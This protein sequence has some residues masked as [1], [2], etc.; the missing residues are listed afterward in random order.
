MIQAISH[1]P[2][3]LLKCLPVSLARKC[4]MV[5]SER[6]ALP[7]AI[8]HDKPS[9][10]Q[11]HQGGR[12]PTAAMQPQQ[13]LVDVSVIHQTD[14]RT[15][16]QRAV[17]SLLLQL[18]AAPPV[19]FKVCPVFA[20]RRHGYRYADPDFLV[21]PQRVT[22]TPKRQTAAKVQ[23]RNGDLFLALDLAAHLLPRHQSQVLNWKRLGTK[24]HVVMYDLLPLQHPEWFNPKTTR[25]FKRWVTWLAIYAD[26][27]I[28]ISD[29]VKTDLHA[30]LNR[31]F[32]LQPADLP[33]STIVLGANLNAS[34]PSGGF[35]AT[36]EFLL[37]RLRNSPTVLMIGT[38]E[39][40]KGY[41]QAL[42]AFE[43]LWQ[44]T[45]TTPILVV[46]GRPG[47]KTQTLQEQLRQHPQ[48]GKRLFW[49]EDVSD[50]FLEELYVICKGVLVASRAEGFGLPLIEAALHSKPI[51]A[52]KL[53][54]FKELDLPGLTYFA[55]DAPQILADALHSWLNTPMHPVGPATKHTANQAVP[56]WQL[57]AHQ[58][59]QAL[60]L[61]NGTTESAKFQSNSPYNGKAV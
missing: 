4:A 24:I 43:L 20:T 5:K 35:P 15:G 44:K 28:C 3:F 36:A 50:E 49:L 19:G 18:L 27:A 51:L 48:A 12:T 39:P 32:K 59:I 16:I 58:L 61:K 1:L 33:A 45:G 6:P 46:V 54:V 38:L 7:L 42:S 52:R 8:E 30:W 23:V 29:T 40:R 56:T 57:S 41:D 37:A 21:L 14:A 60:G 17:R 53:A 55:G 34:A 10:Q 11:H 9:N 2:A 25:N 13:L 47:W 22:H 26:S 31:Y